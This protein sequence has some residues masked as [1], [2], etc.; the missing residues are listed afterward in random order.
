MSVNIHFYVLKYA[1]VIKVYRRFY[2][3]AFNRIK[4]KMH[5]LTHYFL[6]NN[7]VVNI[8]YSIKH[9]THLLIT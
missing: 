5:N 3:Y 4:S 2:V 8:K 7:L 9:I 1:D 6:S